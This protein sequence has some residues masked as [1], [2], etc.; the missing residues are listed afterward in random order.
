M[1]KSHTYEISRKMTKNEPLRSIDHQRMI[2][3]GIWLTNSNII[4]VVTCMLDQ[5]RKKNDI[6]SKHYF[7]IVVP[8]LCKCFSTNSHSHLVV[9]ATFEQDWRTRRAVAWQL[10][11][12]CISSIWMMELQHTAFWGSS[13]SICQ[14]Q[15]VNYFNLSC[16]IKLNR[17]L[18]IK[19]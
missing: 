6:I 13:N 10:L 18:L 3:Q 9:A 4:S 16:L 11:A 15:N 1:I 12:R 19:L 5:R 14:H 2:L 17:S 8:T 7:Y